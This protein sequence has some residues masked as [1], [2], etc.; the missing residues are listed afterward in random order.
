MTILELVGPCNF[1]EDGLERN[2]D[3]NKT[4]GSETR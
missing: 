4:G 1:A 2:R 3:G